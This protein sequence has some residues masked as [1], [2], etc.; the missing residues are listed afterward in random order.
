MD[1]KILFNEQMPKTL[2]KNPEK[3]RELNA[4]YLFNI[5]GEDGGVWTVDLK[6]NPPTCEP[7]DAK[8]A[9]CTI[10]I[11]AAD[12]KTLMGNTQMAM[13][14]FFQGKIKVSGDPTLATR[15][16]ALLKLS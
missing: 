3:A 12:F 8:K 4:I 16:P 11:S 5:L 9:E 1:A 6:S 14:L 13:M 7:G 10:E 15:L 2:L